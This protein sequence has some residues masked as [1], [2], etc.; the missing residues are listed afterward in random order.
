MRFN[1]DTK[2][3]ILGTNYVIRISDEEDEPRLKGCDGFVDKTT[4]TIFVH[5]AVEDCNL[6]LPAEHIHKVIRHEVIHAFMFES[7]LA[8]NWE[9]QTFGQEEMT[10]D[11]FA[12]QL[13]KINKVLGHINSE[14]TEM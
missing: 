11:W 7:G 4:K 6:G 10:I 1:L 2:V 9:H 12:I 14:L 8:E 5:D 3:D 13:P